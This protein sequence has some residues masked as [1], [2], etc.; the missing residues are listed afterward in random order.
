MQT[1]NN[2][3]VNVLKIEAIISFLHNDAVYEICRLQ[4]A[5]TKNLALF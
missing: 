1:M 2:F 3:F 5:L 4:H